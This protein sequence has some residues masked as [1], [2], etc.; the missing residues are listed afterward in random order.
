MKKLAKELVVFIREQGVI[1]LAVGLAIG[2][3]AAAL[4]SAVVEYFINPIVGILLQGTDLS[5]IRTVVEVKGEQ[6][7]FGWGEI[8]QAAITL[9]ATA[10]VVYLIVDKA[11]LNKIDKKKD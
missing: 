11:G 10:F 6:Q 4:V 8:I 9:V 2:I 5:G 1:G 7:V 3:Q